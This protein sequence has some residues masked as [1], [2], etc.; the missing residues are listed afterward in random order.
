MAEK[1]H[2]STQEIMCAHHKKLCARKKL[3]PRINLCA[4]ARIVISCKL[5]KHAHKLNTTHA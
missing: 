2:C 4:R 1:A 5:Q 3:Y